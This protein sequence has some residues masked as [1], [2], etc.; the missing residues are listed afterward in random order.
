MSL[1]DDWKKFGKNTGKAFANFGHALGTTAKVVLGEESRVDEE[2]NS[3]LKKTWTKTG[4]GFG[5]SGKSLGQAAAATVEQTFE[6]D[7]APKEEPTEDVIDAEVVD[8][9]EDDPK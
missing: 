5:E 8:S 6:K 9:G 3:T 1:K 2:G 4:K 7:E